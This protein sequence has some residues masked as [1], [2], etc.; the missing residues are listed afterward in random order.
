MC[1]VHVDALDAIRTLTAFGGQGRE[2]DEYRDTLEEATPFAMARGRLKG[3]MMGS[4]FL[5]Q[6]TVMGECFTL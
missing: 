4:I 3:L 6:L 1:H 2:L 5:Q